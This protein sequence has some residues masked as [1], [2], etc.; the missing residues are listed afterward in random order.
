MLSCIIENTGRFLKIFRKFK[1]ESLYL[2][3]W[4]MTNSGKSASE[5][6]SE[7]EAL[8]R[9]NLNLQNQLKELTNS[10]SSDKTRETNDESHIQ[11]GHPQTDKAL[12]ESEEKFRKAFEYAA[13][14]RAMARPDGTFINVNK[15]LCDM[16]GYKREELLK[17]AWMELTHP[18]DVET[19]GEYAKQLMEGIIPSFRYV[20]RMIH[21]NGHIIW[22]DLTVTLVKDPEGN[23]IYMVGDIVDITDLQHSLEALKETEERLTSFM[24]SATDAFLLFDSNLNFVDANDAALRFLKSKKHLL[25]GKSIKEFSP[26][27]EKSERYEKY[28]EVIKTGKP[29]FVD[30]FIPN[31][32]YGDMHVSIK[33]F[34]VGNGMGMIC[35]DITKRKKAEDELKFLGDITQQASSPVI[36]TDTNYN[37]TWVNNAFT[38]LYGFEL[39]EIKGK[40]PDFLNVAPNSEEIQNEIYKTVSSGKTYKGEALNKK[41]DGSTFLCEFDVFPL[42]NKSGNIIAYSGH[43]RDI[44]ERKR[45]EEELHKHAREQSILLNVSKSISITLNLENVLQTISDGAAELLNI[46]SAAIYLLEED[47]LFLGATTPPLDPQ[48]P[49]TL[50][51]APLTDH[52]HIQKAV[53]TGQPIIIPDTKLETL[54]PA[55]KDI[56]NIRQLRSIIYLPFQ[57]EKE[58]IGVL[59]LG[60][61][62]QPREF[63][64]YEINLCKTISNQL[65]LGVQ[66][67]RLHADLLDYAKELEGQIIERKKAE[68]KILDERNRAELYLDVLSHDINNLIQGLT[69][70]SELLLLDEN[71]SENNKKYAR[72]ALGQAKAITVLISNVQKLTYLEEQDFK[73]NPIDIKEVIDNSIERINKTYG[74]RSFEITHSIPDSGVSVLCNNLLNEVL[75]NIIGNAIKHD[76][77]KNSLIDISHS[78]SEDGKFWNLE[79]KDN[80]PGVPDEMKERIFKRLQRGDKSVQGSGLGLTI[81]REVVNRFG[82]RIWVEDRVPGD[83]TKGCNFVVQLKKAE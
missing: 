83:S 23:P 37:I 6:E 66:N 33:T 49:R 64:D 55:E 47:E 71:L 24:N 48:M 42:Y 81:A 79:F 4:D 15:S 11:A 13:I 78:I 22:I 51:I 5:L 28:F 56:V 62:S 46:E 63:S 27:L 43:Q 68:E 76:R 45:A 9:R 14:G 52:P 17:K 31:P 40:I 7:L 38:R 74:D 67:A 10:A 65:A 59:I 58:V 16:I 2:E 3:V 54:S 70:S 73:I 34:K 69:S 19:S 20:H 8:K 61:Q 32:K 53:S 57:Q 82:G 80:G 30:D 41:K 77:G 60:T 25:T 21:K 18:E 75:D 39:E 72:L 26:G 12:R 1:H 35:T 44:T 29:F 36:T 50:R